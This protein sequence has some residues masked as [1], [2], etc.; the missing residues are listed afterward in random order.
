MNE[1]WDLTIGNNDLE[2]ASFLNL[3][4]VIQK[5]SLVLTQENNIDFG[6]TF[7][8]DYVLLKELNAFT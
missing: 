6:D 8:N 5:E 4:F 2:K 7:L 3:E 1:T